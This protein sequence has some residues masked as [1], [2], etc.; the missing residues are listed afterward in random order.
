MKLKKYKKN[1]TKGTP[2]NSKLSGNIE[3]EYALEKSLKYQEELILPLIYQYEQIFNY[4][5]HNRQLFNLYLDQTWVNFQKKHE[6]NPLHDHNGVFSY[7]IWVNIPFTNKDE[8]KVKQQIPV[9]RLR[10]GN[11]YFVYTNSLGQISYSIIPADKTFENKM[12][13]F[14]SRMFH[15]VYPFYSSNGFRISV[16]GNFKL[17]NV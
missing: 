10:S 16:S 3:K 2:F 1:F 15:T 9:E 5:T 4:Y 6:F 14:P 13:I 12:L 7:V 17:K 8:I 11:F